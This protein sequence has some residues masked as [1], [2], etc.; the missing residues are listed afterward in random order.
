MNLDSIPFPFNI[1]GLRAIGAGRLAQL[2]H[3]DVV[4][5]AGRRLHPATGILM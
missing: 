3:C 4:E 5:R 1:Y 2:F